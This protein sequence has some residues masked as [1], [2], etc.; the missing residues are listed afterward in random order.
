MTINPYV[1]FNGNCKEAVEFY[2][3]VFGS[4]PKIMTFGEM[5][6][7]PN[8]PMSEELKSLV[9]HAC[10]E[11]CGNNIMFSDSPPDM[12]LICGNNISISLSSNDKKQLTDWFNKLS[13]G[14]QVPM[15]LGETFWSK[16]YGFTIDKFGI[17]WQVNYSE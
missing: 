4:K 3:T 5:P 16:L 9:I 6:P 15:P 10:V 14:G 8:F 2:G 1:N 12:E 17:G 7:N 11:I 13:A